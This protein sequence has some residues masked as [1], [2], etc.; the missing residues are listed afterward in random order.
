LDK[1]AD[2]KTTKPV[3][4]EKIEREYKTRAFSK[5]HS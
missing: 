5:A 4:T 1:M 3:K 2:K